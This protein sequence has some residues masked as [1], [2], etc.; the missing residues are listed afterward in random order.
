MRYAVYSYS[1]DPANPSHVTIYA[2]EG[3]E[4]FVDRREVDDPHAPRRKDT[5]ILID[6]SVS[7]LTWLDER[8]TSS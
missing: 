1:D 4:E 5:I 3:C 2:D 7:D 8:I 6:G